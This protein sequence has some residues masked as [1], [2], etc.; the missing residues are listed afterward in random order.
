M[1]TEQRKD[2]VLRAPLGE[3]ERALIE[4]FIHARGFDVRTLADLPEQ[5]RT[6]L[7]R[8]ASTHASAKLA[9]IE[10]KSHYLHEIHE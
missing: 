10:A 6:A 1:N 3:L 5:A 7:L 2:H 9:E 4:T 8:E